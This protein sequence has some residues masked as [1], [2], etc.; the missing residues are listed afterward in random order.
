MTG[1][2]TQG[3]TT[4]FRARAVDAAGNKSG[5]SSGIAYQHRFGPDTPV[6]TGFSTTSP[7][8]ETS[9]R[10]LGTGEANTTIY[11]YKNADC[12]PPHAA[13]W[14][15]SSS[16]ISI[17]VNANANT[18]TWFTARAQDASG[19]WSECSNAISFV[20]D[21]FLP[22][23]PSISSSTPAS[24]GNSTTPTLNG[25]TGEVGLAVEIFANSA[26]SSAVIATGTSQANKGFAIAAAATPNAQTEF[27][28]RVRDAAGNISQCSSGFTYTHVP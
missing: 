21:N 1:T 20:H 17:S 8:K 14:K 7:N 4:T 18:T 16:A 9:T 19:N 27:F 24:P 10:V 28:A 6:L 12:T 23:A 25:M 5:C 2:A 15:I 13:Y 3:A 22:S 26:C 11:I